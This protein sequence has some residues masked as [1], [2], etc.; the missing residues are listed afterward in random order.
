M[1]R[2]SAAERIVSAALVAVG[3][4]VVFGAAA[5]HVR[6]LDLRGRVVL[7]AGGSRGLGLILARRFLAR[8]ARVTICGRDAATLGRAADELVATFGAARVLAVPADVT[9]AY[10]VALLVDAVRE[11]FGPV[12]VLVNNAAT[13]Q[14]GP[15]QLMTEDDY[16]EALD[17]IFWAAYR[18]TEAVLPEMRERGRGAIANVASVGGLLPAPHLAPYVTAKHALVGY[19]RSMRNELA[20]DG[21]RVTTINPGLMRTGS[22]RNVYAKGNAAAEYAWFKLADSLP[23]TS[24]SADRAADAIVDAIEHGDAEITLTLAAKVGARV[25]SLFPNLSATFG[26]TLNRLLP[27]PQGSPDVR[28]RGRE[29]ESTL[30]RSPLTAL[31]DRAAA[32]NNQLGA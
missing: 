28:R 22:P 14:V 8:G 7:I 13:I 20:R 11:R 32:R 19:S 2:P 25:Q 18:V 23:G 15:A 21:V 12:E 4:A 16:R 17:E 24:M 10:D 30:T 29:V 3:A 5:R 26:A 1:S 27:A 31:T 9:R 6:R